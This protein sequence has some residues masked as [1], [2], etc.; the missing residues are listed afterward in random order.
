MSKCLRMF[1]VVTLL[2]AGAGAHATA[3]DCPLSVR[4]PSASSRLGEFLP[5]LPTL[6]AYAGVSAKGTPTKLAAI[7]GNDDRQLVNP[8]Y[9]YRIMGKI[10][11]DNAECTATLISPCHILTAKH[12]LNNRAGQKRP[13]TDFKYL[14]AGG[15][16]A[17]VSVNAGF[18]GDES[19][20][21]ADWAVLRL[22]ANLGEQLGFARLQFETPESLRNLRGFEATGFSSDVQNG[23]RLSSDPTAE[24]LELPPSN[25]F[26]GPNVAAYRADTYVGASGGPL[27]R[28]NSK[29]EASIVAIMS[30]AITTMNSQGVM[31]NQRRSANDPVGGRALTTSGFLEQAQRWMSRN[32]CQ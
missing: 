21:S 14:P 12:C 16:P 17:Q 4:A 24:F 29:G 20:I 8:V 13:P 25:E 32:R 5:A 3:V 15:A 28:F 10:E 27:W 11:S 22:N 19:G 30:T 26:G 23:Q 18:A 31:V 1:I 2:V 7:Y 6:D 9:P